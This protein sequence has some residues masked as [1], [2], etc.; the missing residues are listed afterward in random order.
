VIHSWF[1]LPLRYS[2][3]VL[4]GQEHRG[5]APVPLD[6]P[7][8]DAQWHALA[9][10]QRR[11]RTL[12]AVR[13]LLLRESEVQR[14]LVIFED[15]HWVDSETQALLDAL[16][17]SLPA[18]RLLLLVNYRPEYQD[19]WTNR[20][21][22]RQLR[23]D[24]LRPESAETFLH[25]LMGQ[26]AAL[27]TLKRL[28]IERTQGNPLFLEES[29]RILAETGTL[30]GEL[31]AYRL[32]RAIEGIRVPATIQTLL[33]AR[34]DRLP[35][36]DKRLLQ[37]AAVIGKDVPV[38]LL[39]AI[40]DVPEAELGS[41]LTRLQ[42]AEFLYEAQVFPDILYTFKHV[43]THEVAYGSLLQDRRCLLHR[44]DV[45]AIEDLYGDRL[46]E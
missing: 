3:S 14:V 10:P 38:A 20:T 6:V 40:A 13:R 7:I 42:A 21:Y 45:A 39:Q 23:I 2:F 31:G 35:S 28:L 25:G 1:N 29:V 44:R 22:Y 16:V 19:S 33:A 18:A 46:G 41:P 17:E 12:E 11:Q 26:D 32:T 30:V 24:P 37:S 27:D 15:L 34:I 9:P 4:L 43:L 36:A 8:E 5:C